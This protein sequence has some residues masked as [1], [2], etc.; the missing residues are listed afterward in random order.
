MEGMR[1]RPSRLTLSALA[2][3][4]AGPLLAPTGTAWAGG[5]GQ[6]SC[7]V[8]Y[9]S[10]TIP[11]TSATA[12]TSPDGYHLAPVLLLGGQYAVASVGTTGPTSDEPNAHYVA[13]CRNLHS[14]PCR[15][16]LASGQGH[17][18]DT[19]QVPTAYM[20]GY[21]VKTAWLPAGSYEAVFSDAPGYVSVR[22]VPAQSAVPSAPASQPG[23]GRAAPM[24]THSGG[25][26][27]EIVMLIFGLSLLAFAV[28][29]WALRRHRR[30]HTG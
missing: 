28:T 2:L 6:D 22:S 15:P 20:D 17:A 21:G 5:T 11:D 16:I 25:H 23:G 12:A 3:T 4:L 7:P 13:L 30:H 14:H 19:Y 18:G 1:M 10:V 24:P 8:G 26:T 9:D 29:I 27:G